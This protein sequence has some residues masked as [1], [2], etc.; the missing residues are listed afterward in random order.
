MS[1][2]KLIKAV[3]F[4]L[5]GTLIQTAQSFERALHKK[6]LNPPPFDYT[7]D[8]L[9]GVDWRAALEY[10]FRDRPETLGPL[11]E[12][13]ESYYTLHLEELTSVYPNCSAVVEML[14]NEKYITGVIS[15][16]PD[17]LC[18]KILDFLGLNFDFI[19][20]SAVIPYKKPHP[21]PLIHTMNHFG[22]SPWNCLYI[23]DMPTDLEAA[24]W[25]GCIGVYARYGLH[26]SFN[27]S[28]QATYCID[29]LVDVFSLLDYLEERDK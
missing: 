18:R 17:L 22:L 16:K 2:G 15:N 27:Q 28:F 25:S 13:F 7:A 3:F 4:D 8:F 24:R 19:L 10:V 6:G 12:T 1:D 14:K 11:L 21:A 26:H 9:A 29:N 23:G 5:D 20:G